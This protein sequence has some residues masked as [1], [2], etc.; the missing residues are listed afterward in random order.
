M[1]TKSKVESMK[2]RIL[3]ECYNEIM[4]YVNKSNVEISG[5]GKVELLEDGSMCVTKIYLLDQENGPATTDIDAD[6]MSQLLY[7]TRMDAGNLNFWWHSHVNM[8]VFWSGTDIDTIHQFGKNG[9]LLATVFNKKNEYRTA[10]YQGQNG[11][12]P[13]IFVDDITTDFSDIVDPAKEKQWEENFKKCAREKTYSYPTAGTF[14]FAGGLGHDYAMDD[15]DPY[16]EREWQKRHGVGSSV[17]NLYPSYEKV[18]KAVEKKAVEFLI[19]PTTKCRRRDDMT[20]GE[21]VAELEVLLETAFESAHS[22]A[23]L[24]IKERMMFY[25][26]YEILYGDTAPLAT[27]VESLFTNM[28]YDNSCLAH[29]EDLVYGMG[30]DDDNEVPKVKVPQEQSTREK[31]DKIDKLITNVKRN[32]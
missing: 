14:S 13:E 25:D 3:P 18:S 11:F 1:T 30:G 28:L 6:A 10:Y 27:Q 26:A 19:A 15:C 17:T 2:V 29:L 32:K 4:Y 24:S 21:L 23:D 8:A 16:F 22:Y 7:E 9:Y 31:L 5:M 12:T 20:M